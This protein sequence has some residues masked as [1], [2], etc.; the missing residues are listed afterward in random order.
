MRRKPGP[1]VELGRAPA[2]AGALVVHG[3]R[4]LALALE[5]P[6]RGRIGLTRQ[7]AR[8]LVAASGFENVHAVVSSGVNALTL[9][10]E[11]V[12]LGALGRYSANIASLDVLVE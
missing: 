10:I 2:A 12:I 1:V 4:A 6:S 11:A 8:R 9:G 3:V 7:E 5:E